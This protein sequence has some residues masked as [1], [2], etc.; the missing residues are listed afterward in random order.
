MKTG[1]PLFGE[2]ADEATLK[3]IERTYGKKTALALD[4]YCKLFKKD[5]TNVVSDLKTDKNGMTE[6]D[7][8]DRWAQR[9]MKVDIMDKFDDTMDWTGA[10]DDKDRE[11]EER[12]AEREQARSARKLKRNIKE[13]RKNKKDL[14]KVRRGMRRGRR[15]ARESM[16][17]QDGMVDDLLEKI[18]DYLVSD[19]GVDGNVEKYEFGPRIYFTINGKEYYVEVDA[20]N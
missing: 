13:L 6:W 9:T 15:L 19:Y 14:K 17:I 3:D 2:S 16:D 12:N 7:K 18:G 11:K 1:K 10:E 8:F 4:K 5:L 20:A